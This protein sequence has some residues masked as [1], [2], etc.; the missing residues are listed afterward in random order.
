MNV[1]IAEDEELTAKALQ[2]KITS[3]GCNVTLC[4]DGAKALEELSN[5]EFDVVLLDLKMPNKDGFQV[6]EGKKDTQNKDAPVYVLTN[7]GDD[8]NSEKAKK[9]GAR[10]VFVKSKHQLKDIIEEICEDVNGL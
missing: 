4:S 10:K 5:K 2:N 7:L 8:E 9:L 3:H 1:L 6:L